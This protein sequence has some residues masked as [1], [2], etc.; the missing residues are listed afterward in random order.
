VTDDAGALI[1]YR[2]VFMERV[3][4]RSNDLF[5]PLHVGLGTRRSAHVRVRFPSGIVKEVAQAQAGAVCTVK[6]E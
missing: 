2:Q 4:V 6:E 1:H 5:T 3:L